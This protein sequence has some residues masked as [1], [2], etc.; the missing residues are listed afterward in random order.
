[1]NIQ[2]ELQFEYNLPQFTSEFFVPHS[3]GFAAFGDSVTNKLLQFNEAL[4][5]SFVTSVKG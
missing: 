2:V 3:A 1:V 4:A 5:V